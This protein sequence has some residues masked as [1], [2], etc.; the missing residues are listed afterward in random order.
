MMRN[1]LV[2]FFC[3][4]ISVAWSQENLIFNPSFEESREK[5]AGI[6]ELEEKKS[7]LPYWFTDDDPYPLLFQNPKEFVA[8]ALDGTN[9]LGMFIGYPRYFEWNSYLSGSL[10]KPLEPGAEYCFCISIL[11]HR[12]ST[13]AARDVGVLFHPDKDLIASSN[14]PLDLSA[15][16]YFQ[17]NEPLTNS[18]WGQYCAKFTAGG[19][20][21]YLSI[22][23]FGHSPSDTMRDLGLR[24]HPEV[25]G[26]NRQAFYHFDALSLRKI[27][28]NDSCGCY[29][30]T[31]VPES[32]AKPYIFVLDASESM[33]KKGRFDSLRISLSDFLNSLPD[34]LPISFTSFASGA[35]LLY[36]GQKNAQ[37]ALEIDQA[38]ET[39]KLRGSTNVLQGLKVA[40]S[41][42]ANTGKDSA[43][44]VLI[45]DGLFQVSDELKALLKAQ[46][47]KYNRKLTLLQVDAKANGLQEL[48]PYLYY[49]SYS[50]SPHNIST[51]IRGLGRSNHNLI[52]QGCP[53]EPELPDTLNYHFVVDYSGSMAEENSASLQ[54]FNYLFGRIPPNA[55]VS[56][57]LFNHQSSPVYKGPRMGL[58][59]NQ[60]QALLAEKGTTGGTKPIYGLDAALKIVDE[61]TGQQQN[62]LIIL[63]D[64]SAIELSANKS[65]CGAITAAQKELK[66]AVSVLHFYMAQHPSLEL[67]TT[68]SQFDP[69]SEIF[70]TVSRERFERDLFDEIGQNCDYRSEEYHH[71][72]RKGV[73]MQFLQEAQRESDPRAYDWK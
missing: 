41:S 22:G 60:A 65:L 39:E 53:C 6:Y 38:L 56:I 62:A 21:R 23:K 29:K 27:S 51:M 19:G 18:K 13:L 49:Y 67:R 50:D 33:R 54:G 71:G 30:N 63:T 59:A 68:N 7:N 10:R 58:T 36:S 17:E 46:N 26:F 72:I 44:I 25:D 24:V 57:T 55:F 69:L 61:H 43:R 16:I 12:T 20:E 35:S 48:Q 1:C 37:T 70:F 11:L 31:V 52:A 2:L 47:E 64:L 40:C 4:F 66:L 42:L 3:H 8:K 34:G 15:S 32:P 5:E 14:Q 45:S 73:F 9:T 28:A